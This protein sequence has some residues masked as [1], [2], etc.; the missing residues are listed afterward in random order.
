MIMT[1]L[2][3]QLVI[4]YCLHPTQDPAFFVSAVFAS[5]NLASDRDSR[6]PILQYQNF[7]TT[8]ERTKEFI[9]HLISKRFGS[10]SVSGASERERSETSNNPLAELHSSAHGIERGGCLREGAR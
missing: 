8:N 2:T 3:W 4:R 6:R 10:A 5:R 1:A 7:P 9:R